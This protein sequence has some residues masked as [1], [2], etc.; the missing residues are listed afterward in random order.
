MAVAIADMDE[1]SANESSTES[2]RA[3]KERWPEEGSLAGLF[4]GEITIR[5][6]AR[7]KGF[8]TRWPTVEATGVPSVKA[9]GCNVRLLEVIAEWWCPS[10]QH[11]CTVPIQLMRREAGKFNMCDYVGI[12]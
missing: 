12:E 7:E 10:T 8:I 9:M 4:E 3:P 1:G 5:R 6:R 11:C 2:V